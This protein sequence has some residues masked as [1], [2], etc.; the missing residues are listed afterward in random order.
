MQE[1]QDCIPYPKKNQSPSYLNHVNDTNFENVREKKGYEQVLP[2]KPYIFEEI[3]PK[4]FS[5][6]KLSKKKKM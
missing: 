2:F 4:P 1:L 3:E 5:F 6:D